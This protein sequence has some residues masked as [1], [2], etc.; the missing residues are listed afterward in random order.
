M[1][2]VNKKNTKNDKK[3]NIIYTHIYICKYILDP[4]YYYFLIG[5]IKCCLVDSVINNIFDTTS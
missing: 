3:Y 1:Y 2:K 5:I 4:Y